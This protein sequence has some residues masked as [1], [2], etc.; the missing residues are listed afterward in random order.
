MYARLAG[1]V[2]IYPVHSLMPTATQRAI[3][4][5]PPPGTR[6]VV[7]AT[8]IAETSITIDDI[9]YVVD[10]GKIKITNFDL[11]SNLA[12]LQPEWVSLANARQRRGRAGRVQAGHCYH[13]Y[14]RDS[15]I[16]YFTFVHCIFRNTESNLFMK[17]RE[18]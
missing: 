18:K 17:K 3:F 13:L 1:G 12:T 14:T 15:S 5:R 6:K 8:N 11:D 7:I 16:L 2:A 4:Q 9:V 10:C